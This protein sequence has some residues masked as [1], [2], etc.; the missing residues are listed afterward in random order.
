MEL[1][2][3]RL[4]R[5]GA[6]RSVAYPM[7]SRGSPG[8][9]AESRA[10]IDVFAWAGVIS[11]R[12]ELRLDG[13]TGMLRVQVAAE[14]NSEISRGAGDNRGLRIPTRPVRALDRELPVSSIRKTHQQIEL[15]LMNGQIG[16]ESAPQRLPAVANLRNSVTMNSGLCE[17]PT[18]NCGLKSVKI[19]RFFSPAAPCASVTVPPKFIHCK[20]GII[21][22]Q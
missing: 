7:D 19:P 21:L 17:S 3:S 12:S 10:A 18:V 1:T 5:S 9:A 2:W 15:L 8:I 22:W 6:S 13:S 4:Y 11:L 20:R 14:P 16:V